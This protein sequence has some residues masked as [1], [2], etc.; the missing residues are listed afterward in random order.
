MGDETILV[1]DDVADQR[2]IARRMLGKL[3]Y[4]VVTAASGEE[5]VAYLSTNKVD[6]VVLDMIM[7]PGIDGLETY[8]RIVTH[9]P[10]QKAVV[11]SGFSENERVSALQELGA[12]EYLRKPYSLEK[13]GLAVRHE[14]DRP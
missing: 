10:G 8:R 2:D 1:V 13:I 12:G 4:T 5:A 14:L 6:L 3:G 9:H 11:A 7:P